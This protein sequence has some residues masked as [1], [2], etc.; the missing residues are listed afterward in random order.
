MM[1]NREVVVVVKLMVLPT[2]V[3]V[4]MMKML[5]MLSMGVMI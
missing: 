3:S 5:V 2:K 1:V 4:V